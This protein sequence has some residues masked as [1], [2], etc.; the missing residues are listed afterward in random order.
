MLLAFLNF[1]DHNYYYSINAVY[2]NNSTAKFTLFVFLLFLYLILCAIKNVFRIVVNKIYSPMTESLTEYFLN[3]IY[4]LYFYGAL[5]DFTHDGKTNIPY[6]IINIILSFIISFFGCVY[7]EFII[8]L[9][10]GLHENTHD[11]ITLRSMNNNSTLLKMNDL[12]NC[13][14]SSSD[15][16]SS[17]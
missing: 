2:K 11:Q 8:L 14:N 4:I 7:N 10:C 3:P 15:S 16:C 17:K 12:D 6:F 9:F 13:S 5:N 1:F